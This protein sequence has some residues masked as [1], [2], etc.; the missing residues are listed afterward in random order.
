MKIW[1]VDAVIGKSGPHDP[2]H[3]SGNETAVCIVFAPHETAV[4]KIVG[5]HVQEIKDVFEIQEDDPRWENLL[6]IGD[7]IQPERF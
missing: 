5:I 1:I 6:I 3:P 4:R 2:K 7:M